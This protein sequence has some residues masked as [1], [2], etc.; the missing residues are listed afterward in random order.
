[1]TIITYDVVKYKS[2]KYCQHKDLRLDPENRD[3]S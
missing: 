3:R 1:M 2:L